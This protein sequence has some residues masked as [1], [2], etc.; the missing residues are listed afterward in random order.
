VGGPLK[1]G[2]CGGYDRDQLGPE[3]VKKHSE[4][5][6]GEQL[7]APS[8]RSSLSQVHNVRRKK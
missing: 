3:P 2:F 5:V 6:H 8:Q 1:I 7:A 4:L